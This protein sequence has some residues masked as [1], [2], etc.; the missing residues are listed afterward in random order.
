MIFRNEIK[1][2]SCNQSIT[3]SLHDW[4]VQYCF[5]HV[6]FEEHGVSEYLSRYR[7]YTER[8]TVLIKT[9]AGLEEMTP[10]KTQGL[11]QEIAIIQGETRQ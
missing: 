11:L 10:E 3:I 6:Q 1:C 4:K 9:V 8:L 5:L 2:L 7:A